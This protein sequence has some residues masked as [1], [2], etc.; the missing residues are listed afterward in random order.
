MRKTK[1]AT[2]LT[3]SCLFLAMQFHASAALHTHWKF[4]DASGTVASDAS[5]N[6]NSGTVM[7]RAD[8]MPTWTTSGKQ[9]GAITLDSD[10]VSSDTNEADAAPTGKN[11][12]IISTATDINATTFANYT[13]S[14]WV[15]PHVSNYIS[16]G[17][18][19]SSASGFQI[20]VNS[21]AYRWA[22]QSTSNNWGGGTEKVG[23]WSHLVATFNGTNVTL[24]YDGS[25]VKSFAAGAK[26][27]KFERLVVGMNRGM[28]NTFKGDIDDFRIYDT[29]LTDTE[30]LALYSEFNWE[31]THYATNPTKTNGTD[32]DYLTFGYDGVTGGNAR[33]VEMWVKA[34]TTS[35]MYGIFSSGQYVKNVLGKRVDLR[36][37]G[38]ALRVEVSGDFVTG[39][40][41]IGDDAWHH[42][43]LVVKNSTDVELYVDG[44]LD[45]SKSFTGA[46]INT[47]PTVEGIRLF[48]GSPKSTGGELYPDPL[49][50]SIDSFRYWSVALT[51]EQLEQVI[52]EPIEDDGSGNVHQVDSQEL[53]AG[54]S[55]TDLQVYCTLDETLDD[56]SSYNRDAI[57]SSEDW[58]GFAVTPAIGL[59]VTLTDNVLTWSVDYE[60][61]IKEYQIV[62]AITDEVVDVVA[63]SKGAYSVELPEGIDAK[64]VIVDNSGFTQTF[65]PS[66]GNKVN[67]V[68]ELQEGWNLIAITGDNADISELKEVITGNIWG[69]NGTEYHAVDNP[70]ACQGIWVFVQKTV[71]VVVTADKTDATL[72]LNTGWNLVGPS[73]NILVPAEAQ[74]VYSWNKTYEAILENTDTLLQGVGYWIFSIK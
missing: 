50:M 45:V 57:E 38:G 64:L 67:T 71:Q 54:L 13:I 53:V 5:G 32:L 58:T 23:E 69:W 10:T 33:T 46:T 31:A 19:N 52:N 68:Y 59:E 36:F 56:L 60:L 1:W 43:A 24:Y 20:D 17:I 62:D 66:D 63:A 8:A 70:Q 40:T 49:S 42:I 29:A 37:D 16:S 2:L 25:P 11:N 34:A 30:V 21:G 14:V 41:Q 6:G 72:S 22:G 4:D 51:Q 65:V 26:D 74:A 18:F 47:E 73:E 12:H 3:V 44:A 35:G 15:R 61:G 9:G 55:W 7:G 48:K 27:K 39:P 28:N